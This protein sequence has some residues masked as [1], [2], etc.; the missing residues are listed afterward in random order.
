[1]TDKERKTVNKAQLSNGEIRYYEDTYAR[2]NISEINTTINN[3]SVDKQDKLVAGDGITINGNVISSTSVTNYNDLR[4]KP[5]INGHILKGNIS[6]S[7][8]DIK[9][10]DLINDEEFLN[11]NDLV[12]GDGISIEKTSEG[13][14]ISNTQTSAEWGNI[15]GNIQDQTDLINLIN[16]KQSDLVAGNGIIIEDLSEGQRISLDSLI[17]DCGTSVINV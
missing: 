8:L 1:M 14:V 11:Y 2:E 12:S 16:S 10:S 9:T 7:E 4:N 6:S 15:T 17:L 13:I 5:S 3:L